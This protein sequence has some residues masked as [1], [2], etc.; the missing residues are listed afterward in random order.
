MGEQNNIGMYIFDIILNVALIRLINKT[1]DNFSYSIA[2]K[3]NTDWF[4]KDEDIQ[5]EK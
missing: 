2:A 4:Y 1:M 5:E 3:D